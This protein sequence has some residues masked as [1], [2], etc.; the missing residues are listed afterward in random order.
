MLLKEGVG[1]RVWGGGGELQ[2]GPLP[3]GRQRGAGRELGPP[4]KARGHQG[5][6][7]SGTFS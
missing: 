3:R 4:C 6:S 5:L 7:G 2:A 1:K